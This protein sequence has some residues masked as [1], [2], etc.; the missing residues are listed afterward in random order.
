MQLRRL[1]TEVVSTLK[2]VSLSLHEVELRS[3]LECWSLQLQE[4]GDIQSV[5]SNGALKVYSIVWML[6]ISSFPFKHVLPGW[7]VF[8]TNLSV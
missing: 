2:A 8:N 7:T 6:T 5:F 1:N 3:K 4:L